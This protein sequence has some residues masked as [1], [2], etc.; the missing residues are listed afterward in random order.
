MP[1]LGERMAV[2]HSIKTRGMDGIIAAILAYRNVHP[3]S[4]L[5]IKTVNMYLSL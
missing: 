5:C 2:S 1:L 4:R 3:T